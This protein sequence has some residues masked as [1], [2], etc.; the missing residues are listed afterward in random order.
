M[1]TARKQ[2]AIK[3]AHFNQQNGIDLFKD[4]KEDAVDWRKMHRFKT[5]W[6]TG[7][8]YLTARRY[9]CNPFPE[10]DVATAA[11]TNVINYSSLAN[12]F[13]HFSLKYFCWQLNLKSWASWPQGFF[14]WKSILENIFVNMFVPPSMFVPPPSLKDKVTSKSFLFWH[15]LT[16]SKYSTF[17]I[18][19]V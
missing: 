15:L 11:V 3:M 10:V 6:K 8:N 13:S 7:A 16:A 5:P 17:P 9:S 2:I 14:S 4:T 12:N 1:Q 18:T 19:E